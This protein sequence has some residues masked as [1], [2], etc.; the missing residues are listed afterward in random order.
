MK[1]IFLA[2][3]E[4]NTHR[5]SPVA[6]VVK[7]RGVYKLAYTRGAKD[8]TGFNGFGRMNQLE[9]EYTSEEL[10][11][12]LQNRVLPRTRPEYNEYLKWLGLTETDHDALEELSRTGGLRAT[13]SI[14]LIPCPER[15]S[16]NLYEAFF[17]VRGI[18]FFPTDVELNTRQLKAGDRLF[19]MKDVQNEHDSA[20]L[21]LRTGE[22]ISL[23]GYAPR[24]YSEDFSHL[25][26]GAC[27]RDVEVVVD[28]VN[29]HAPLPY[30]VLCRISAPWPSLFA[31]CRSEKFQLISGV[32]H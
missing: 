7:E 9:R 31:A 4:Q 8:V 28:R 1:A 13:D 18:R 21:L 3:Q 5:W 25:A 27:A 12:L 15:N 16:Q 24:Y 17:F 6:R 11:P 10:F 30:R 20:A 14:E 26:S 19:L 2:L 32:Q 22:P 23:V 29:S